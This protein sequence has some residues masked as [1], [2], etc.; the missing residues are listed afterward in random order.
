MR[1]WIGMGRSTQRREEVRG[2]IY[3][4]LLR[5]KRGVVPPVQAQVSESTRN[6][7]ILMYPFQA[8]FSCLPN[9]SYNGSPLT[10]SREDVG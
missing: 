9:D 8:R 6:G 3:F 5:A 10:C 7:C 2:E 4:I 1:K